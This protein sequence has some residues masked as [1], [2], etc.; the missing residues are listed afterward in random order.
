M[1][2]SIINSRGNAVPNQFVISDEKGQTFQSYRTIIAN[3][4]PEGVVTLDEDSWDYS[5]TTLRHLKTFLGTT[6][7][8]ATICKRIDSGEYLTSSLK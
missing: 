7:S 2:T 8:K 5:V 4:S 6:A 1:I 3:I